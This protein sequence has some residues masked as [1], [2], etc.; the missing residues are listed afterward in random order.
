LFKITNES[1][2]AS[3]VR[4]I[5]ASTGAGALDYVRGLELELHRAS[6]LLKTSPKELVKRVE[7]TQKRLKE[8]ERKVEQ[9]S[10]KGHAQDAKEVVAQAREINGLKV[11]V[12]RVDP[13]D[14]KVFRGLADQYRDRIQSGVVVLGGEKDG[15]ALLLVAVTP[16]AVARGVHAGT[17]I[18]ELAKEVGGSGGGKPDLAQAGGNDPSRIPAALDKV[19]QLISG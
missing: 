17:L 7:A 9:V 14:P 13:A 6:E 3:G 12:T 11:I 18:R 1:S 19:Y 4:R 8:L 15:K 16:D 5:V 2:I 10:V